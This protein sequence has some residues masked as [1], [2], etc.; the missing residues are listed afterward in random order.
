[1][2][3]ASLNDEQRLAVET[4]D[5]PLLILAGAGSGKTRVITYRIANLI[6]N[7]KIYPNQILAVTFTNKA[8][9][10]MRNRCRS[11]LPE[12]TA[13]PLVRTFH[14]LCLYLLRRE[15]KVL[16]LGSNFTVYDSDMQESLIKE[17]LKSKDMDTKEFRPSSLAN[18][19][20]QAKDSFLTAEEF[21][22]KKVDDAYSKTIASVFLEYEKRKDLRNALDFGDLILKTVILF[23]DFPVILEKYQRLWK[24]IMVDEYQDTNKIQYHLVQSLSSFHKNLCVVGDDDQSIY[25]WRGADISNILNFK[26]D[27]P[28]AVVVKLEEN[29]RS[30]RTIIE[31]AAALISHN[32]QRTNK[33]LRTENP[34]GDKIKFT[35]FQ[36]EMEEAE[37]IVQKI[38]VGARKGQKYS[39]FAIFYRTNSQSR[40]FEE[41]LRKRAIPYKI[42]GGFRFFDRKEVKDLIAYLSVIVNPVD[43]TSLLRIINSPP[44]GIGDTT[45]NRILKYSVEEGLSLYECLQKQVPDIKKGTLQKLNSL[46]RMFDSEMEDLGKKTPS[47]IAY[48]VLEHSGYREFLENE[49]TED[50]FSRLSNLNEFV[51]ALKEY[52]ETNPEATLEEY[53]SSISLITSEENTKD[54]PDYVILMTVHN[55]KGLEFHH[56]F[57]AGMEEG[58]FPHFLSIDSPEGIEEE[59]RLAYVAITRARKHLDISYSR[60]TRKFGEVDARFP[61]QFLEEIPKEYMEGEFTE[62]KY[63]VRRPEVTPR[64]ERFQKSEEKFESIQAKVGNGEFQVG[65]QVRHKV[66]G[67]GRIL[68]ISGSGDNRKVEVRFG[69]HLDKKFLLAYT[70]LEI[71]S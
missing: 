24:Y 18:Q 63:G 33:T 5:G 8:A 35:S 68:S 44:R 1:M 69:S 56:V 23:R 37:G 42:F 13:E 14:S 53:L 55:A 60:F 70:P 10:E 45:V 19:F 11:L 9:E 59:R 64:A 15:G 52:E 22:K 12:G 2:E 30:T 46:Y 16:G 67:E 17:I 20:S 58:T 57:M 62:T 66:Y 28:E 50:S 7:H 31:S 27:Y 29:Y 47:E 36:N 49:G 21:A 54:L 39:N 61:S 40:Y 41:A 6:L 65:T 71:I 26:K 38:Q 51:N 25:S 3:L 32:K 34:L 48:D 4:V 43:S